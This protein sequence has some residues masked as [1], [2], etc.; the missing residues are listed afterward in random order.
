V[1]ATPTLQG[2]LRT[3]GST[4]GGFGGGD[5]DANEAGDGAFR[6]RAEYLLTV[7]RMPS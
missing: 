1:S 6:V 5:T 4:T 2:R 3:E 7:A